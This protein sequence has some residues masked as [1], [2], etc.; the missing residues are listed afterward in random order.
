[1]ESTSSDP[2]GVDPDLERPGKLGFQ[3]GVW[4]VDRL[5][6]FVACSRLLAMSEDC[7]QWLTRWYL[8]QCN[9]NW[10]HSFGVEIGALDIP[11]W[12]LKVDL[13]GTTLEERPFQN[14]MH[15]ELA[16]DLEEWR[17]TGSWWVAE[18]KDSAFEAACGP[19][20]LPSVLAVFREWAEVDLAGLTAAQ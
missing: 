20:D 13:R 1:M 6:T 5:R 8:N 16:G 18:V 7:L 11:G 10:E 3:R 19:L 12:T 9:D 14:I 2:A 4:S 17:R 15:G